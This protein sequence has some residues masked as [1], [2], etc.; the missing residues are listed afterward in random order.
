MLWEQDAAGSN[1]VIPIRLK[2]PE[3]GLNTPF[4]GLFPFGLRVGK[5][6]EMIAKMSIWNTFCSTF[7]PIKKEPGAIAPGL[8]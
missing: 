2:G 8:Y 3:N 4:L 7:V 6:T 1:P 5:P